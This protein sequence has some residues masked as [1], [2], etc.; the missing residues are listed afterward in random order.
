MRLVGTAGPVITGP[1][2]IEDAA[3]GLVE[4]LPAVGTTNV[5]G[6]Y[7]GVF[8]V[9]FQDGSI[10]TIPTVGYVTLQITPNE[11]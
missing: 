8:V 11:L 6:T 2:T 3:K 9:E 10:A 5:P 7:N 4:Y 1:A